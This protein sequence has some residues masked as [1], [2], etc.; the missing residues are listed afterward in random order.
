[1][2]ICGS[3]KDPSEIFIK[4]AIVNMELQQNGEVIDRT[5]AGR[6]DSGGISPMK[7]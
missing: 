1:L 7:Q 6:N 5:T 4:R 2:Q 3:I